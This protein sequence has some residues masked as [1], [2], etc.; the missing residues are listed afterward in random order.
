VMEI[1]LTVNG[2]AVQATVDPKISLLRF[3]R[4]DFL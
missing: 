4:D 1:A 3:L 2:G